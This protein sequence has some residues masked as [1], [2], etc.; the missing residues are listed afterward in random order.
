MQEWS[1]NKVWYEKVS[2]HTI[3]QLW[4]LRGLVTC[5]TRG[6]LRYVNAK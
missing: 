1:A 4:R 6:V 5:I 2:I 3:N